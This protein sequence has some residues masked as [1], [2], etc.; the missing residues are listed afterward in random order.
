MASEGLIAVT[1][2]TG[3]LG[4]RVA[5]RLGERGARLRVVVRDPAR[6]R[7]LP[8][9]EVAVA[10][11]GDAA[12]MRAALAGVTTMLFVSA[13]ESADRVGEHVTLVDAAVAAGVARIVYMS[14]LGAAPAATFTLARHHWQTEEHIRS[15]GVAF[16][17]LRDSVYL[18]VLPYFVGADAAIRGPAGRGRVGA[19]AR[20]DI[21]DAAVTVL[22][23][24]EHHGRTY[25]LTGPR[26]LTLYEV[27]SC[28]SAA[29]G[30]EI[31]YEPETLP[32]AYASRAHYGAPDWEV[33]G[34]VTTYAAI[35][36]GEL[37]VVT[38]AVATLAGHPPLSLA[39][40]LDAY[41][42]EVERL[43]SRLGRS[44]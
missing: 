12:A 9:A 43:R 33:E 44:A 14:F 34:W 35:A 1:G 42:A 20:D 27:A 24:S 18:D 36:A 25:D 23:S 32:E 31:R 5:R 28:L 19:V 10:S 13:S 7:D 15:S 26:A 11:Y 6:M 38:D 41:P 2:V 29:T 17:F 37:E 40:Y 8:G 30:A 21:A 16:T 39:Q 4:G 22:L 3:G